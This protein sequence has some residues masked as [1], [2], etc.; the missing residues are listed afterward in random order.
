MAGESVEWVALRCLRLGPKIDF[1]GL[2]GG[3]SAMALENDSKPPSPD[4]GGMQGEQLEQNHTKR[5]DVAG[6]A[7]A[8]GRP[9]DPLGRHVRRGSRKDARFRFRP[10]LFRI[11]KPGQA[12]TRE[13]RH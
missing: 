13:L 12:K 9:D 10:G 2:G 7:D 8:V 5:M 6:H 1:A 3:A 11:D 4:K